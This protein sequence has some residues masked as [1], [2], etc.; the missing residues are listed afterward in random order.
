MSEHV[1]DQPV[2]SVDVASAVLLSGFGIEMDADDGA[3][4]LR[5]R[6]ELDM[7]STPRLKEALRAALER[8]PSMLAV[9]LSELGF[10]DS[11][12]I[13]ALIGAAPRAASAGCSFVLRSPRRSVQ[14][15]LRLTG[16][17]QLLAIEPELSSP[18]TDGR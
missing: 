9:D 13:G 7:A 16:V 5:L 1:L 2:G 15:V 4:V 12:G 3:V 8:R 18:S 11:V 6:G 17:E 14:R 10:I